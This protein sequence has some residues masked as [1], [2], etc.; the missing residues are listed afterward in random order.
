MTTTERVPSTLTCDV[1][2]MRA[3]GAKLVITQRTGRT[4]RPALHQRP[5]LGDEQEVVIT[6]EWHELPPGWLLRLYDDE[7]TIACSEACI[8]R[9]APR[10]SGLAAIE[11]I[12]RADFELAHH[13]YPEDE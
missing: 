9:R 13:V 6:H 1:C 2:S 4:Y 3:P 12:D 7:T 11:H 5:E 8:E 10:T